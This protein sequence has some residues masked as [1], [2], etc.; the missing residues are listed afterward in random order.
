MIDS[1]L[2]TENSRLAIAA[3]EMR[4]SATMRRKLALFDTVAGETFAGRL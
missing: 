4:E 1:K 3:P 2:T